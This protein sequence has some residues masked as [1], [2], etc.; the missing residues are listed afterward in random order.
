MVTPPGQRRGKAFNP[1]AG[2]LSP[3]DTV[4][5]FME[6][7]LVEVA[8]GSLGRPTTCATNVPPSLTLRPWR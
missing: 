6:T 4:V 7:G 5:P 3:V 1:D 2:I 8:P